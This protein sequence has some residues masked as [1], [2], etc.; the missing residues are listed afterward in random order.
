MLSGRIKEHWA[1]GAMDSA[2]SS[3][4]CEVELCLPRD[5][6]HSEQSSSSNF[7][8]RRV[9]KSLNPPSISCRSPLP[10]AGHGVCEERCTCTSLAVK[11]NLVMPS[12]VVQSLASMTW[13]VT[14]SAFGQTVKIIL[15][16][17]A[18]QYIRTFLQP[19]VFT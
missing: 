3:E 2:I 15:Q 14:V 17:T 19:G 18:K 1:H 5:F 12:S 7:S 13:T 16:T 4:P 10:G 9:T 11:V 6:L 8:S